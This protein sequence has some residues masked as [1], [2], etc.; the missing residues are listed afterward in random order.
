MRRLFSLLILV[1]ALPAL[2]GSLADVSL[3]DT[4]AVGGKSLVLNGMGLRTKL[5][6]KVYVAGL[7]VEAKSKNATALVYADAPKQ[8]VLKFIYSPSAS[9]MQG[10]FR[11]GFENNGAPAALKPSID[12]FLA[13]VPGAK[14]GDEMAITYLPGTGTTL[15]FNGK[16]LVTVPGADFMRAAFNIWLG[17]KPPTDDLKTG[18]LG[19]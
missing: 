10:A 7:Y 9:Q 2:A 4:A 17:P 1:L 15:S 14:K 18:M 6:I 3:P 5:F 13:A 16:D 11:E 8:I 12:K 19:G